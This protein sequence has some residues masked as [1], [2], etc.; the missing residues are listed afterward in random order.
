[1]VSQSKTPLAT[2]SYRSEVMPPITAGVST[3][4][5]VLSTAAS[6]TRISRNR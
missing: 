1:M 2:P 3:V 6:I 4:N 5:T